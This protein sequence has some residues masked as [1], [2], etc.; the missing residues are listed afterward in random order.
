MQPVNHTPI[1]RRAAI[2]EFIHAI[3]WYENR[4]LGLDLRFKRAVREVLDSIV[5][6]PDFYPVARRDVRHALVYPFPYCVYYR[7]RMNRVIVVSVFHESR[8]PKE[9]QARA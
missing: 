7:V 2:E 1:F 8:D 3:K 4:E 6:Q 5:E 9:W